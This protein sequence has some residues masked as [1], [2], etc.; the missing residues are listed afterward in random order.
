LADSAIE[1]GAYAEA[2]WS[3]RESL[4]ILTDSEK[5][6]SPTV[7]ISEGV[8]SRVLRAQGRYGDAKT[9]VE[10]A[11]GVARKTMGETDPRMAILLIDDAQVFEDMGEFRR[12]E[13]L[14]LQA[15]RIL[16]R[17]GAPYRINLASA[18]QNLGTAYAGRGRLRQALRATDDA[19]AIWDE[20]LPQN[21]P[22]RVS[23]L[24]TKIVIY[25]KL[26]A[27]RQAEEIIPKALDLNVSRL[28][29]DSPARGI[30]LIN[31]AEI[32]LAGKKYGKAE[33]LLREAV[34]LYARS[35]PR[36]HPMLSN[37]LEHYSFVLEKLN[38]K[39]D[40]ALAR[41]RSAVLPAAS[42]SR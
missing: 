15:V 25:G 16:E 42:R 30:L 18:Y 9:V 33:P 37:A 40:A 34:D 6:G 28:G 1:S 13:A 23:A 35:F 11:I 32:Y 31:A 4:R 2:E 38:R 14:C 19:L 17:L 41:A 36:G 12:A 7:A 22:F 5:T 10:H 26:G 27:L 24:A 21:D 3:A 20:E 39:E 8:L 29:P